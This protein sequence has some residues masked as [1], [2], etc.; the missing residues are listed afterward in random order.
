MKRLT[1]AML[2]ILLA[3]IPMPGTAQN[4]GLGIWTSAGVEKGLGKGLD[5][6]IEAGYRLQG[7]RTDSRSI[8]AD[9]SKRLWR[10]Q[11]KSFSGRIGAAYKFTNLYAPAE[12]TYQGDVEDGIA[13]GLDPEYYRE[14]G[15]KYN[16]IYPYWRN[17]H[18][19]SVQL[20]AKK[21]LGRFTVSLKER[22]QFTWS[23]S[24]Q[25]DRDK[26]RVMW[27]DD[28]QDFVIGLKSSDTKTKD[29]QRKH[30]LR[31][32]FQLSYD[33]RSCKLDPFC[34]I[35]IFNNAADSLSL[36]KMRLT[37]GVEWKITK[38]QSLE[39]AYIWQDKAS[40][41]EASGSAISLSYKYSF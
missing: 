12:T 31:T 20:S 26:Y 6:G 21:E 28:A 40:D 23:D 35:D 9:V 5:L 27:D 38:Q 32:S 19:F 1:A 36:D 37:V 33:I 11:D 30:M 18:R 25:V 4:D 24:I 22:Y 17:R 14:N 16:Y 41:D 29:I 13:D 15:L 39:T 34:G 2:A 8:S 3:Q 7:S 10:S